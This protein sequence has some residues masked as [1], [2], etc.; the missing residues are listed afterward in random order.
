MKLIPN[1]LLGGSITFTTLAFCLLVLSVSLTICPLPGAI[2][3]SRVGALCSLLC[4][5]AS[6]W[7][8]ARALAVSLSR[9]EKVVLV[10]LTM[11]DCGGAV[12]I[13]WALRITFRT[14]I[15]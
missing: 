7:F 5:G 4:L 15:A 13:V 2:T 9:R 10:I 12:F 8:V 14:Q 3:L 1:T 6:L 11:L